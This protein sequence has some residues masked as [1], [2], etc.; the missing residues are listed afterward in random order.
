IMTVFRRSRR[1]IWYSGPGTILAVFSL[2]LI[3]GFSGT[4]FYP[5][6][7]DPGSSLTIRN[8]SSSRFTLQT[9]MYVSFIIPFVFWYIW[10]A[11]KSISRKKI[12]EEELSEEPHLY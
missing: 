5:S 7:F 1:G 6:S 9:M 10:Y 12:S 4:A 11:W 2:F 8:A 3:A